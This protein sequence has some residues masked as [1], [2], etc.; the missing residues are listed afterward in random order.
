MT[1]YPLRK[2]NQNSKTKEKL[3]LGLS[4]DDENKNW[5]LCSYNQLK[6]SELS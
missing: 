4:F 2:I 5:N 3:S 1:C 6:Y